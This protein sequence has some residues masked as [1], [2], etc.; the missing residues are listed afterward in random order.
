MRYLLDKVIDRGIVR[1]LV[2]RSQK[3][4]VTPEE[5]FMLDLFWRAT[6]PTERLFI[7]PATANILQRL[8]LLPEYSVAINLFLSHVEVAV[9]TRYYT[10]C[11]CRSVWQQR[12]PA[13]TPL[14][15][16]WVLFLISF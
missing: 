4:K 12:R 8:A 14:P 1:S 11:S 3:Q 10:R 13:L 9:P 7:V 2:K 15:L 6:G 16:L 5:I